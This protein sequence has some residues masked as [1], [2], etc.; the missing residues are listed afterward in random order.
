MSVDEMEA[1]LGYK[2]FFGSTAGNE[3]RW[4]AIEIQW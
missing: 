4:W 2:M 3:M 1:F